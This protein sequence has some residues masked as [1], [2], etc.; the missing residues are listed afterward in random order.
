MDLTE[1]W[2]LC[3]PQCLVV[4][5]HKKLP[6]R[7]QIWPFGYKLGLNEASPWPPCYRISSETTE[8]ILL[9]LGY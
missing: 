9:K 2:L 6:V 1:T 4:Q 8:R 3:S 5:A 7:R